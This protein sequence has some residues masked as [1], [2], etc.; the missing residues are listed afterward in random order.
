V[1]A[2]DEILANKENEK[3]EL[4]DL[5]IEMGKELDAE[6]IEPGSLKPIIAV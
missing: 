4:N 2:G 6:I 3:T 1:F 5:N